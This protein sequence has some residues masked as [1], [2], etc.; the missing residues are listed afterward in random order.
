L[1][2]LRF[3]VRRGLRIW[4]L[5]FFGLLLGF[6]IYPLF[7][8][9][10]GYGTSKILPSIRD[11]FF[12]YVTF[13]GNFSY[14]S[15]RETLGLYKSLW[16][17]CLEEQFYLVFPLVVLLA[18]RTTRSKV[19]IF[20]CLLALGVALCCRVYFQAAVVPY[21]WIWVMPLS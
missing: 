16:T 5:Y 18:L 8:A 7:L 11:H 10:F 4:P 20:A 15:F 6:F 19:H 21:P 13:V 2:V 12:P 3:Y 9:A 17:V 1:D 14:A